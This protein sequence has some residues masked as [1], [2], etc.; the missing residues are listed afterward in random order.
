MR[1][2]IH[3]ILLC[4]V[5]VLTVGC[6]GNCTSGR[7]SEADSIYTWENIR[8]SMM[9]HPEHAFGLI[10]TAEMRGQAD[11]NHA[12]WMRAQIYYESPKAEDLDKARDLCLN[13]S[14]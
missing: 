1:Q 4:A 14:N 5:L 6:T 11:V 8:Q 10:D 2:T 7:G 13:V 12:N 3:L 9:E